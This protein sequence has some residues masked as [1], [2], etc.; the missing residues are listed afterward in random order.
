[1]KAI[2]FI[3]TVAISVFANDTKPSYAIQW[4]HWKPLAEKG[5]AEA[6]FSLGFFYIEGMGT[7]RD[8]NKGTDLYIKSANKG[9][10]LAQKSL[11]SMYCDNEYNQSNKEKCK[12]WKAK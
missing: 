9:F 10:I 7:T 2:L 5:D 11:I 12:Y 6:Q 1:M 4:N 3:L 8:I